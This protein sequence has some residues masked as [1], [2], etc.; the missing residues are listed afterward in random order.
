MAISG[1]R[2]TAVSALLLTAA[3][4]PLGQGV[5]LIGLHF[6]LLRILLLVCFFRMVTRAEYRGFKLNKLDRLVLACSLT[7][8]LCGI[9]RGASQETFGLAFNELGTY[10]VVRILTKEPKDVLTHF[11]FLITAAVI[12]AVCMTVE[13]ATKNNPFSFLGGEI[14]TERGDRVRC[15]GPF[16]TPILAGT[17]GVIVFSTMLGYWFHER[18]KKVLILLAMV[19]GLVITV[20]S[21]SSG[22]LVCLVTALAAFFL[23][24]LRKHFRIFRYAAVIALLL[25]SFV[26]KAPVWFLIAKLSDI[27]G[28]GGWHRSY[29]ID[30]AVNNFSDWWLCGTSR[31]AD[32]AP[33][34]QVLLVDP[35]NI[36]ITNYYISQGVKGG[37]VRLGLFIAIIVVSFKIIGSRVRQNTDL[38]LNRKLIWAVG[39]TLAVHCAAFISVSYFDQILIYWF[40]TVAIISCLT[41]SSFMPTS[42]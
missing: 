28:G 35:D 17:F 37:L 1:S 38:P 34:Y 19:A 4:M 10:F 16:L 42:E 5:T 33:D 15:Q 29:I 2:A 40:W 18:R 12:I 11:R 36:D 24:P 23:W 14:P 25:A 13:F 21:N 27:A 7:G 6:Q 22:P 9:I 30:L 41:N 20:L 26:M 3:L 32:W 31:T 39:V 8:V